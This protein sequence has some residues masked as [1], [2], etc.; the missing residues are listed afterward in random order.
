MS[1]L[2]NVNT[3]TSDTS[4][5]SND[6]MPADFHRQIALFLLACHRSEHGDQPHPVETRWISSVIRR[7]ASQRNQSVGFNESE[8]ERQVRAELDRLN[9]TA[10]ADDIVNWAQIRLKQ[11]Q[12]FTC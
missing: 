11:A 12:E 2:L 9:Q 3:D 6:E 5:T 7:I 1:R 4:D 10:A 8:F